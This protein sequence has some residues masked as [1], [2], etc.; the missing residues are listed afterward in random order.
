MDLRG[1]KKNCTSRKLKNKLL[2]M[3]KSKKKKNKF[4]G[5]I[6]MNRIIMMINKQTGKYPR[7]K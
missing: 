7:R 2:M 5:S 1:R 3:R 6:K 4:K